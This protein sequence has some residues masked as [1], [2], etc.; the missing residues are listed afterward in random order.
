[1]LCLRQNDDMVVENKNKYTWQSNSDCYFP[2]SLL[3]TYHQARTS[4]K[5]NMEVVVPIIIAKSYKA[6]QPDDLLLI[7]D[8][9]SKYECLFV[10]IRKL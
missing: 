3:P 4:V 5:H 2:A 8:M 9:A 7:H 6:K 10:S 1:M